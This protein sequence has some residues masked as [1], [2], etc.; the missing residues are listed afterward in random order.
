M[1][2]QSAS[3]SVADVISALY[4]LRLANSIALNTYRDFRAPRT[5]DTV[6]HIAASIGV[7]EAIFF[8]HS[9]D[10]D[11]NVRNNAGE[12]PLHLAVVEDNLEIVDALLENGADVN[13]RTE[14]GQ[15]ALHYAVIFSASESLNRFVYRGGVDFLIQD[16]VGWTAL[17][18]SAVNA[19]LDVMKLLLSMEQR[20]LETVSAM[21]VSIL[22]LLSLSNSAIICQNGAQNVTYTI[23][24][25]YDSKKEYIRDCTLSKCEILAKESSAVEI[26][27]AIDAMPANINHIIK[28]STV[29][30]EYSPNLFVTNENYERCIR[31]LLMDF[32]PALTDKSI[33]VD[34]LF[35]RDSLGRTPLHYASFMGSYRSL[36]TIVSYIHLRVRQC[37]QSNMTGSCLSTMKH[38]IADEDRI[39]CKVS[40]FLVA[41]GGLGFGYFAHP[42]NAGLSPLQLACM[43]GVAASKIRLLST[44][45]D[46]TTY[47][48][49]LGN[50]LHCAIRSNSLQTV[51]ELVSVVSRMTLLKNGGEQ[52]T[53]L[54]DFLTDKDYT[55]AMSLS[56]IFK[57]SR[58]INQ[59]HALITE[60]NKLVLLLDPQSLLL[61]LAQVNPL[62]M[63]IKATGLTSRRVSSAHSSEGESEESVVG[64]MFSMVFNWYDGVSIDMHCL[65]FPSGVFQVSP[66]EGITTQHAYQILR[67]FAA[68]INSNATSMS[69]E[70]LAVSHLREWAKTTAR[71]P[72]KDKGPLI[73]ANEKDRAVYSAIMHIMKSYS[74]IAMKQVKQVY[75]KKDTEALQASSDGLVNTVKAIEEQYTSILS[76]LHDYPKQSNISKILTHETSEQIL[77]SHHFSDRYAQIYNAILSAPPLI[78]A[79]VDA[80]IYNNKIAL[81]LILSNTTRDEVLSKIGAK[82]G[83]AKATVSLKKYL[84]LISSGSTCSSCDD[85]SWSALSGDINAGDKEPVS[86]LFSR[87]HLSFETLWKAE[88]IMNAVIVSILTNNYGVFCILCSLLPATHYRCDVFLFLL[89]TIALAQF[90]KSSKIDSA[91]NDQY[92]KLQKNVYKYIEFILDHMVSVPTARV[93][94]ART[95]VIAGSTNILKDLFTFSS[96]STSPDDYTLRGA[97]RSILPLIIAV[98][99]RLVGKKPETPT[100]SHAPMRLG[101]VNPSSSKQIPFSALLILRGECFGQGI[102]K[103]TLAFTPLTISYTPDLDISTKTRKHIPTTAWHYFSNESYNC[104]SSSSETLYPVPELFR[105]AVKN[106]VTIYG[107]EQHLSNKSGIYAVAKTLQL[108]AKDRSFMTRMD[109]ITKRTKKIKTMKLFEGHKYNR[110]VINGEPPNPP[111]AFG[112]SMVDIE[113]VEDMT[114]STSSALTHVYEDGTTSIVSIISAVTS[115]VIAW[116]VSLRYK[117]EFIYERMPQITRALNGCSIEFTYDDM[118][119]IQLL[120]LIRLGTIDHASVGTVLCENEHGLTPLEL[121]VRH[122]SP[123]TLLLLLLHGCC[124]SNQSGET[125]SLSPFASIA[126]KVETQL[127]ERI[128]A[129]CNSKSP[130]ALINALHMLLTVSSFNP[131]F[132]SLLTR[133]R[134]NDTKRGLFTSAHTNVLQ[135]LLERCPMKL[136][137]VVDP[138]PV[139]NIIRCYLVSAKV[140]SMHNI[141]S[142]KTVKDMLREWGLL[143]SAAGSLCHVCNRESNIIGRLISGTQTC[144]SC[145]RAICPQCEVPLGRVHK[146]S[147]VACASCYTHR[148]CPR[149]L[150]LQSD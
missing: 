12:T 99:E 1:K 122:G 70:S 41:E 61:F 75:I 79:I 135:K 120:C 36:Y 126:A 48:Q 93:A 84:S 69:L 71:A 27:K 60:Y 14:S 9:L 72:T 149:L 113:S 59:M 57:G 11:I 124:F 24:F 7:P 102:L 125:P 20:L 98:Q 90:E 32:I 4:E 21:G 31:W 150:N 129:A 136:Q 40:P 39:S 108:R 54:L 142:S 34:V 82:Y 89:G 96:S 148:V 56:L 134:I 118:K 143:R 112:T 132:I 105:R 104:L 55:G 78:V 87:L 139:D 29:A 6:L 35:G 76:E 114:L 8:A 116:M 65:L 52:S 68:H 63:L 17:H 50:A 146:H 88:L 3:V 107:V 15:T 51:S 100:F 16:S 38:S 47:T 5:G 97:I 117:L 64:E 103:Y 62:R 147:Y 37:Y 111:P 101:L 91:I 73:L 44:L 137:F 74:A 22:H 46:V 140:T 13:R 85:A 128:E 77:T 42:D 92:K 58:T 25:L 94:L 127:I 53:F 119:V 86:E 141:V 23:S 109:D 123:T 2:M 43:S 19:D 144:A 131:S 83:N 133:F 66:D 30:I 110:H 33:N 18:Y 10:L 115:A 145:G 67:D 81:M 28:S 95:T 138:S 121:A 106:L 130:A 49:A 45:C 80:I 26:K